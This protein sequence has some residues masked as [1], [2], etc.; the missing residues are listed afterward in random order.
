MN[1]D[2]AKQFL[3]GIRKMIDQMDAERKKGIRFAGSVQS[4][5]IDGE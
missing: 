1:R 4:V 5:T 2:E 3:L